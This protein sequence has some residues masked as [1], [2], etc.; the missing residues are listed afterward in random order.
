ML[1]GLIGTKCSKKFKLKKREK[2]QY[3][4]VDH[5]NWAKFSNSNAMSLDL[6]TA[7]KIFRGRKK[8]FNIFCTHH[9]RLIYHRLLYIVVVFY[10]FDSIKAIIDI[11][12]WWHRWCKSLLYIMYSLQGVKHW[13]VPF[14]SSKNIQNKFLF[15]R[16]FLILMLRL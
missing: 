3:F 1:D 10:L 2:L 7:R 12:Q 9:A 11:Y 13:S 16:N 14:E 4:S 15:S 6:I 8:N 5:L